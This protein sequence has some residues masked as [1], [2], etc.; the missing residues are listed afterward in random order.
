MIYEKPQRKINSDEYSSIS[1]NEILQENE[2]LLNPWA[3]IGR[4]SDEKEE[5]KEGNGRG[6]G[7]NQNGGLLGQIGGLVGETAEKTLGKTLGKV[8]ETSKKLINGVAESFY[9]PDPAKSDNVPP[10][11]LRRIMR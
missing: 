9:A 7:N 8:G 11:V 3:L 6:G 1:S 4:E 10:H 5:A 2:E